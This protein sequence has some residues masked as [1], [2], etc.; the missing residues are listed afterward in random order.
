MT[1]EIK[2][3]VHTELGQLDSRIAFNKRVAWL[4]V[5]AGGLAAIWGLWVFRKDLSSETNLSLLGS[6][7]QGAV[8]S[9]WALAGLMFIY[10]AFL[11]QKQQLLLQREEMEGQETQFQLQ[12]D[13]I[14]RQNFESAFFQLLNLHGQN[15]SQMRQLKTNSQTSEVYVQ[16]E[17][18]S[19]FVKWFAEMQNV[20]SASR[21][22]EDQRKSLQ[23]SVD[24]YIKFY[25]SRQANL[26]HYFRTLYHVFK[27]VED[28]D[29]EDKRR[30]TS[31][32]R[33]QLS[34]AELLLLFYNGISPHG[35]KFM[36]IIVKFG[37]FEHLNRSLLLHQSHE[38]FY[39][40]KAFK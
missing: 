1:P 20:Y 26:A 10:V 33:A 34:A 24:C 18:R 32:V 40:T 28:S 29:I 27:F 39:D 35:E 25:D 23:H 7:F 11:G 8:G 15:I 2:S 3:S 14:K 4:L 5:V 9:L 31:L 17:G 16:H 22:S 21:P 30:Y 6:Y 19:C 37:L 38:S 36:P 12:Q 13:S